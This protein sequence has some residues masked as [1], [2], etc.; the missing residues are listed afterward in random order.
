MTSAANRSLE[1][2]LPWAFVG[3][4]ASTVYF[5]A[6]LVSLG[7]SG[8]SMDIGS[9]LLPVYFG[10]IAV[11]LTVISTCLGWL[12]KKTMN[13][14]IPRSGKI[15]WGGFAGLLVCLW[16]ELPDPNFSRWLP[17]AMALAAGV[18]GALVFDWTK[19]VSRR[20]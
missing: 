7:I 12:A 17:Y 4:G 2:M 11:G 15:A 10:L 18:C 14:S 13:L 16:M 1:I 5:M 3:L 6:E 19:S 8:E 9:L 20:S